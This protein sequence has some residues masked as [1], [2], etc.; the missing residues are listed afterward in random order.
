MVAVRIAFA[1]SLITLIPVAAAQEGDHA[2]EARIT[3]IR[4]DEQALERRYDVPF[5]ERRMRRFEEFF[6][7]ELQELDALDFD[8]LGVSGRVDWHALHSELVHRRDLLRLEDKQAREVLDAL[9]CLDDLV[10]LFEAREDVLPA[11]AKDVAARID[12]FALDVTTASAIAA[13]LQSLP[14]TVRARAARLTE[15]TLR[16]LDEY[17]RFRAGYDPQFSWWVAK[18]Y[19]TAAGAL[20]GLA[21]TLRSTSDRTGGGDPTLI[22]DPIGDEALTQALRHAWI[23]YTASELIEIARREFAVVQDLRTKAAKALGFDDWREAQEKVKDSYV[24]PGEQPELIRSLANEAIEWVT[25]RD[26]VTVP[27]LA[28]ETWRMTM[29]SPERQ[30]VSP[31]FLGGEVIQVSYPTDTMDHAHKLMSMRGNNPAFS[32]ATVQHEL[33]PGH[34]LQQFMNVRYKPYRSMFR[35]PFWIEGWCLWWEL[36]LFDLGFPKTKEDEIGMLFW[37]AHR[38]ARIVFSLEFQLG[39]WDAQKCIDFLVAEVG[40]ERRN[41][42]AEVRRSIGGAYGPLYQAAYLLGGLQFR[43]LHEELCKPGTEGAW[44][45]RDFHD[46]IL[47]ENTLPIELLRAILTGSKLE[48]AA[49]PTWRFAG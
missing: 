20:R 2:L 44:S 40:H 43:A 21:S 13:T 16:T 30:L 46:R 42:T 11:L 45:D 24:A 5:S 17:Y 7:S 33:I 38:C 10:P 9:P 36:H 26:L 22:G 32:R 31:Y 27:P 41:A 28:R 23:P 12:R 25:S 39:N 48:K 19:E 18:P 34:H 37:R 29:L 1:C 6:D 14:Q 4:A 49:K 15:R 47:R 3:R 35:T 8:A